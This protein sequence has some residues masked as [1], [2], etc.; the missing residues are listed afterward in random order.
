MKVFIKNPL[1]KAAHSNALYIKKP[2]SIKSIIKET[3]RDMCQRKI[4]DILTTTITT[5]IHAFEKQKQKH[6]H[7]ISETDRMF[8][9]TT[10]LPHPETL[11][12]IDC[13]QSHESKR[14][15]H[16]FQKS[17]INTVSSN[18]MSHHGHAA[19]GRYQ[20]RYASS[21]FFTNCVFFSF[22]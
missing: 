8:D 13:T 21:I 16:A 20:T 22:F 12:Q 11:V 5:K 9:P 3:H 1:C 14:N 4:E 10:T 15:K 6:N 18:I 7:K 2:L 19:I 17:N